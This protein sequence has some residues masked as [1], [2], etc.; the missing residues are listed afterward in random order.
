MRAVDSATAAAVAETSTRP[1]FLVYFLFD[2][3]FGFSS[4][5]AI[6]FN[7]ILFGSASIKVTGSPPTL[8]IFNDGLGLGAALL[9]QGTTG[10]G[11][12]VLET[13]ATS[14]VT[15][16]APTGYTMPVE[17]FR[18]EMSNVN[19]GETIQIKCKSVAPLRCPRKVIAPPACNHLPAA[20]T[21]I[22]MPADVYILE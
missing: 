22:E 13:Y 20:G 4:G 10:R 5:E 17:V 21:R 8:E 6:T 11:I 2:I 16:G 1:I 7:S 19:I 14:T 3:P 15:P 12:Y 18:G 9:L